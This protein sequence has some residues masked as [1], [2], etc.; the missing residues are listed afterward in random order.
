[1]KNSSGN[2]LRTLSGLENQLSYLSMTSKERQEERKRLATLLAPIP[3]LSEL[4]TEEEQRLVK[5]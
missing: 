2:K 3:E 5:P 4:E 1:M